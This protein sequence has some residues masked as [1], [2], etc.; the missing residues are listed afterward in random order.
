MST[1]LT[2]AQ[3][4]AIYRLSLEED[5]S[6]AEA[7][8]LACHIEEALRGLLRAV[9]IDDP[10]VDELFEDSHDPLST[11]S[12]KITCGWAFGIVDTELRKDLDYI[13][14]IRNEFAHENEQKLFSTSPVRDW[15]QQLSP[16]KNGR[17]TIKDAFAVSNTLG[18]GFLEKVYENALVHELRKAGLRSD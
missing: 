16:V 12:S 2:K 17:I 6:R 15:F 5:A 3:M 1:G 13:R 18:C 14:K 9:M 4:E 10:A 7:I 11:F 8:T